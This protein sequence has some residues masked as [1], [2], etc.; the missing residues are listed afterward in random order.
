MAHE[1]LAIEYVPIDSIIPFPDNPNDGDVDS[2]AE[3]IA[4]FDQYVP[5]VV[6]RSTGRI[7]K[8]NTTFR[9]LMR[10][11]HESVAVIFRDYDDVTARRVLLGDNRHRDRAKTHEDRLAD[12]LAELHE[13]DA[14]AGTGYDADYLDDLLDSLRPAEPTPAEQPQPAKPPKVGDAVD[15]R[16]GDYSGKIS[17]AVYDSFVAA[18][19]AQRSETGE[20]MLDDVLALWLGV[21][22]SAPVL[23]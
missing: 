13:A 11:G 19:E 18:Y 8:G 16:C 10:T 15:F 3:S 5:L 22:G 21:T 14:L 6:Q 23:T 12:W 20:V 1:P 4:E 2:V 7:V 9:A 17:R